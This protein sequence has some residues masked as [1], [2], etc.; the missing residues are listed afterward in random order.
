[1]WAGG[2][3][4]IIERKDTMSVKKYSYK[5]QGALFC[6]KYTQVREMASLGSKLYSDTV[7]IDEKL[8]KMLDQLFEKLNC[9]FYYISSGYRTAAHDK[10]VGGNGSGQHTK[11]KA[12]DAAFYD[13]DGKL[14]SAKIVCCV[15][16]DLK[17]KG[18]ANI[19]ENY[20]YV[21]LDTRSIGTY[22]GDEIYGTSSVTK[23]FYKYFGVTDEEVEKY[24]QVVK[25]AKYYKKYNGNSSLIDTVLKTIGVPQ[26]HRGSW[27]KRKN[28]ALKNGIKNYIGSE[29]QNQKL[30]S[31]AKNGK[32]KKV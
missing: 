18:I 26:K 13:K 17:F 32:L 24:T 14:I 4:N 16:Q 25:K 23:D 31:L 15:A 6:S 30:I 21:H 5:K 3:A 9:K 12:L 2:N 20:A 28:L 29:E 19:S 1:M 22:K 7:L 10:A 8:M 27:Q 11:G